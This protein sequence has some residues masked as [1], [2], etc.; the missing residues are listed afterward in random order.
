MTK[1][2]YLNSKYHSTS[3]SKARKSPANVRTP[4]ITSSEPRPKRPENPSGATAVFVGRVHLGPRR[5]QLLDH[6]GMAVP[7]RPM[8]RRVASGAE[9]ARRR[10]SCRCRRETKCSQWDVSPGGWAKFCNIGHKY[11]LYIYIRSAKLILFVSFSVRH[12]EKQEE[13]SSQI[14]SCSIVLFKSYNQL[15]LTFAISCVT[16]LKIIS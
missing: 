8:Q 7:S 10:G 3:Q 2:D 5:D 6:G 12:G 14:C 1:V 16:C 9:D 15:H 11:I 13:Q 4:S